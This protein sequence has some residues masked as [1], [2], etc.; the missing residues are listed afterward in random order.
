MEADR[1]VVDLRAGGR[2]GPGTRL[3]DLY[4][5]DA[6]VAVGGMGEVFRGHAIETGDP[7]AIKVMRAE[8]AENAQALALFRKEAS[9]LHNLHH[10]AVVRY[11]VFS[12]DRH[13]GLPYL[14]MEYVVGESLADRLRRGPLDYEAVEVLRRRLA[15]GLA[16]AHEAG[17]V[18]RDVT[19]DNIILPAADPARAKIIDFGIARLA[20]TQTVIGDGFAGKYAYASPEQLGLQG[21]EITPRSDVYSLGLVLAQASLGRALDMG[22]HPTAFIA[23]RSA[24]P[25]LT[26][27][28]AR[29][30]PLLESMLRPDPRMRPASMA[31]I[32]AWQ[33]PATR[34]APR[35]AGQAGAGR[36]RKGLAKGLAIGG[37]ALAL[38]GGI[39]AVALLGPGSPRV[40][41]P[42]T[43]EVLKEPRERATPPP[44]P[45]PPPTPDDVLPPES[46]APSPED[47]RN[48]QPPVAPTLPPAAPP[49]ESE[50]R[51]GPDPSS[52]TPPPSP[53]GTTMEQVAAYIRGYRGGDCFFLNPT[54]VSGQDAIVEAYG[55]AARP[56]Q[57]FDEAFRRTFGFEAKIQLRQVER[58]QCAVVD[59]LARQAQLR[60]TNVPKLRLDS[61]RL[62]S[63]EEL[64]GTV[65]LGEAPEITLL[66][67]ERDGSVHDLARYLKRAGRQARFAVRLE[68]PPAG[69]GRAQLI[70]AVGS[71]AP[72]A[73]GGA[74]AGSEAI[75]ANLAQEL[76]RPGSGLG[77]AV[78]LIKVWN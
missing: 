31:E 36:G 8:F 16:A 32:E 33:G 51:P 70:L 30:V 18:H 61:D 2:V 23:K 71:R 50:P 65:E 39:A 3:N 62:R 17:I 44:T 34:L 56:F 19:P 26:G 78:R 15:G 14:A 54:T 76:G 1:T 60:P 45:V 63:G 41:H 67:V 72:L 42:D 6:L 49:T 20:A 5:I 25:D 77:L 55:T 73:T 75:L 7:V 24:V 74:Q 21:G 53:T 68:V 12:V 22:D 40:P 38:A 4:E 66:L 10:G 48:R 46:P 37:A 64:R 69:N 9:A 27:I 29:L 43:G 58:G 28:D 47:R 57:D 52:P 11:Y 13:L 35:P 59:L